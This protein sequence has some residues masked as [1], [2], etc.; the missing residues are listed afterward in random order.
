MGRI[1]A[2]LCVLQLSVLSIARCSSINIRGINPS[3]AQYY[4]QKGDLFKCLD[5]QKTI[6]YSLINDNFCD[7]FD[8]SDEPG[9]TSEHLCAVI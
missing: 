1:W 2:A 7:C 8:G 9:N 5:G 4:E 3:L 6:M